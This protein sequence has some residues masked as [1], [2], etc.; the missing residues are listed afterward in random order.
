M[1]VDNAP[2][3]IR[4]PWRRRWLVVA[5]LVVVLAVFHAPLLHG[6]GGWLC[7]DDGVKNVDYLVLL[8][9][10]SG[11]GSLARTVANEVR[12]G[13]VRGMLFFAMPPTR[14]ERCGAMQSF[15]TVFR[16]QLAA[17]GV[18]DAQMICLPGPSRNSWEAG[19]ALGA[20]LGQHPD[21]HVAV[22]CPEFRGRYERH[23]LRAQVD[24]RDFDRV[25]FA[26]HAAAAEISWWTS[27]EM[28]Q[29]VFQNYVRLAFVALNG[30]TNPDV[31]PWSYD[32]YLRNLPP[33]VSR[34]AQ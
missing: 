22:L 15:E 17:A 1:S 26:T 23:V 3:A 13:S 20:W 10:I 9:S 27:R 28:I 6:I 2:A 34:D 12:G 14:G 19:R 8:P 29:T 18:A 5:A 21:V 24:P 30:E 31:Q 25:K 16:R 7:V 11:D 33:A 4:T 32:E